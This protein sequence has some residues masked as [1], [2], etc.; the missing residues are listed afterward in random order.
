MLTDRAQPIDAPNKQPKEFIMPAKQDTFKAVIFRNA[1]YREE[2][3]VTGDVTEPTTGWTVKLER[4][5]PQGIDPH[6][7]ILDLVERPPTGQAGDV[8]TTH[9]VKYEESPPLADYRQVTI[10]GA[11]TIN[12]AHE[13]HA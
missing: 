4:A 10:K 7:L 9:H 13:A 6:I 2:L 11:F 1:H 8:V 5:E 3:L 12:V